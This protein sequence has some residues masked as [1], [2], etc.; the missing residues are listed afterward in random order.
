ML[1]TRTIKKWANEGQQWLVERGAA[2]TYLAG[3]INSGKTVG[4]CLKMIALVVKYPNSRAAI[5]RRSK[6]QLQKTTM[7]TWYQ[8]CLPQ[9]YNRGHR[10]ED[11]LTL[12]NGSKIY[13]IHL[14]QSNSL[15]LLAGLELNFAYPSQWEE[16]SE[17]ATDLLD[18]RIGRWTGAVI[19]QED[20]DAFGGKENWPW[21]SEEGE[22]VPPRYL[23]GEGYVTDEGHFLYDRF[24][25]D[26]PNRE[27]WARLGYESRIV[28]T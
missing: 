15:D 18:V 13:F 10:T 14:D 11:A 21:K 12:N 17:K 26:S 5:I 2:P 24:A 23:F 19:P 6:T 16:I 27:K 25:P 20:F 22:C 28:D 9:L 4:C 1:Q 7:E 3:G 8:W